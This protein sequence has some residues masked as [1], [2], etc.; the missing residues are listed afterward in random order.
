MMVETTLEE[1]AMQASPQTAATELSAQGLD[2]LRTL[3]VQESQ[4]Q[5]TQCRQHAATVRQLRGAMDSDSVLEREL[6]EVGE[7]RAREAIAEI[8]HALRRLEAGE[9]GLCE[10]CEAPVPFERLE[11]VPSARYCVRCPGRRPGWR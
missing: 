2:R 1:A 7:A 3:L 10:A 6:A 9:Y 11:A 4:V 5:A 8:E